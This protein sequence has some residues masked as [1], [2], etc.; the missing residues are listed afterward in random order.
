[1]VEVSPNDRNQ[2]TGTSLMNELVKY[3]DDNNKEISLMPGLQD[4]RKG[5]TSRS[6][7]VNFYKRFGFVE[8][9]GRNK[10]FTKKSGGMYY[11]PK[12]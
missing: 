4:D 6:R 11:K 3:A 12:Q 7:L 9:K 10:D 2:G 5:T 8:N 1:M